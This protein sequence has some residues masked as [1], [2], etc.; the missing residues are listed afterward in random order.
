MD[1]EDPSSLLNF[2]IDL[3]G[4]ELLWNNTASA[5]AR[6]GETILVAQRVTPY[7]RPVWPGTSIIHLDLSAGGELEQS[8][9]RAVSLGAPEV[10]PQPDTRWRVLL[11]AAGHPF[12]ITTMTSD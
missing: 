2:Y 9:A 5:R 7:T 4:G 3:R 11:D 8:S 6:V 12:C 1:C 10:Y